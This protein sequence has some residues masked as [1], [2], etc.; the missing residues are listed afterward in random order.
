[1]VTTRFDSQGMILNGF[2]KKKKHFS[3][4]LNGMRDFPPPYKTVNSANLSLMF[5]SLYKDI[6][7]WWYWVNIGR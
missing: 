5:W 6:D 3:K 4:N 2:Y 7:I 1:M